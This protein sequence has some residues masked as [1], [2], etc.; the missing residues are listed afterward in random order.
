M[1]VVL[2]VQVCVSADGYIEDKDRSLDWFA[3]SP[4][5]DEI[6]T[7]TLRDV[8]GMVFGRIAH[9]QGAR[10]WPSARA[11]GN[12][13]ALGEQIEMMNALPKY[14]LTNSCDV[15]SWQNSRPVL[16]DD[17]QS[18]KTEATRN[19]VIFAGASAIQAA[20]AEGVVDQFHL[21]RFPVILGGG[22]P[23]FATDGQ[24]RDLT[25]LDHQL[26]AAGVEVARFDIGRE[27]ES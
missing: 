22:T 3:G 10:Y 11:E 14:V 17:L 9:E 13:S 16:T 8:E 1:S 12:S 20:L 15:A 26:F 6:L 2:F 4:V 18:L 23:L 19:L 7:R 24:R 27:S 5:F 21:I 25:L